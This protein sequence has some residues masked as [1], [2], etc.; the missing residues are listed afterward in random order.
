[1]AWN[2]SRISGAS[3]AAPEMA[4]RAA[5]RPMSPRTVEKATAS[6]NAQVSSCSLVAVPA[7]S[8][9]L[10]SSAAARPSAKRCCFSGSAARAAF[11]PECTFS[12][13]RGTPKIISGW[14]SGRRP[15]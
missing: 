4:T 6:R 2:H 13:T 12:Q 9:A 3:G 15:R 5:S 1:M 10:I 8:A 14:T 7:R 11:T